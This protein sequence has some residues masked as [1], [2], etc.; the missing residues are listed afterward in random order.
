MRIPLMIIGLMGAVAVSGCGNK[1]L[2]DIR[3]TGTGPDEF[4]ILPPK[5]LSE[6]ESYSA[7][8]VPTP[9]GSN[10]T[11]S[12]PQAEAVAALGGNPNALAPSG[13]IP[14]SDAGLVTAASRFGVQQDVREVVAAEDAAFLKRRRRGGRI[15]IAPVDRYEQIYEKQT[16]DPFAV[17]AAFREAGI[18]TPSAPPPREE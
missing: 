5:P 18:A 10:L 3:S 9:G 12:N 13:S 17:N 15:K 2:R 7:L 11:D 14:A 6:P 8:P 1:E 16:L 4:L